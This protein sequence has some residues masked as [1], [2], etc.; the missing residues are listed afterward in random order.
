[1]AQHDSYLSTHVL[2]TAQGRPGGGIRVELHR[3][4]PDPAAVA[5]IVA[6]EGPGEI[7]RSDQE[8]VAIVSAN[9]AYGDLGTAADEARRLMAEAGYADG[10]EVTLDCPNNRYVDRKSVV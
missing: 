3:L 1:M 8:R 7:R 4:S 10:F 2:D 5:D 6:T 9:L